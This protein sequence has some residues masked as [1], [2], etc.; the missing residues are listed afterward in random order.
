MCDGWFIFI[1]TAKELSE[2]LSQKS[3]ARGYVVLL[4]PIQKQE[5]D[6]D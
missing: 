1:D 6:F 3:R 4:P 5:L 2:N